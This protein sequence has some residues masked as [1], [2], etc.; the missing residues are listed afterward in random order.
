MT[1]HDHDGNARRPDDVA[2]QNI[3]RLLGQAYRPEAPDPAFVRQLTDRLCDAARD[4]ARTRPVRRTVEAVRASR[5]Q[6][7]CALA[8]AASLTV[9]ALGLELVIQPRTARH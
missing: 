1:S 6:R 3:R 2:E 4:A 5:R 7:F 8:A 9:L